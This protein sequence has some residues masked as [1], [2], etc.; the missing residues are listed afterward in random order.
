LKDKTVRILRN[1]MNKNTLFTL[2]L[3]ALLF[4]AGCS[5]QQPVMPQFQDE[6]DATTALELFSET[7]EDATEAQVTEDVSE[8]NETS[9]QAPAVTEK[10]AP[11]KQ[12]TTNTVQ[13]TFAIIKP[14][15]VEQGSTG[16][17]INLIERNGFTILKMEK[18]QLTQKEAESFYAVHKDRPFFKDLVN[19]M[20]SGPVVVLALEKTN[21]VRDWRKLMGATNPERAKVG[22]LRKMFGS[23]ITHNATHGSDSEKN[24]AIEL[25]FFF[26]GI[27]PVAMEAEEA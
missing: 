9:E 14:D 23:D 4:C 3:S 25:N 1:F 24:A 26:P 10:P 2:L 15:A 11:E 27:A 22:T 5:A 8:A 12:V 18:K 20:T 6:E 17:I 13:T 21:A 16:E 7:P 19:F